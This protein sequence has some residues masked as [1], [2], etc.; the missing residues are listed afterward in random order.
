MYQSLNSR[1]HVIDVDPYGT[2]SIFLNAALQS[3]TE[4]G[5]LCITATDMPVLCGKYPETCFA[6]YGATSIKGDN[7]HEG[8]LRVLLGC[9]ERHATQFKRMIVPMVSLSVDYYVRVFVRV[10]TSPGAVKKSASKMGYVLQCSSCGSHEVVP[11]MKLVTTKGK[12]GGE[13]LKY[14]TG[15]LPIGSS[16]TCSQCQHVNVQITGPMWIDPL[17]DSEVLK[18]LM[19]H[20]TEN[21]DSYNSYSRLFGFL[22]T[23][24]TVR[25]SYSRMQYY[26]FLIFYVILGIT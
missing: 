23:M 4:G 12:K 25:I 20:L 7:C 2:P 11:M 14:K 18:Q 26:N 5:M 6:K 8:A 22:T 10:F 17:F 1:F 24:S 19:D 15:S 21:K 16:S 9:V 3:V 13:S